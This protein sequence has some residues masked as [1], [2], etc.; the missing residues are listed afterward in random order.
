MRLGEVQ[1]AG[2]AKRP[3]QCGH[4]PKEMP[5]KTS[6]YLSGLHI[7]VDLL[8]FLA[9]RRR[10]RMTLAQ[11]GPFASVFE[12]RE[13]PVP[14]YLVLLGLWREAEASVAIDRVVE[15]M[16]R[17][18]VARFVARLLAHPN[19]RPHLVAAVAYLV[20]QDQVLRPE[21][22]WKAIDRGSWVIPQLVVTA[23]FVDPL[24]PV[25]AR[26]RVEQFCPVSVLGG[27]SSLERHSATGPDSNRA[28]SAK[29]MASLLEAA[30]LVPSMADWLSSTRANGDVARLLFADANTDSPRIVASWKKQSQCLFR[31]RG[32]LLAPRAT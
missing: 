21:W 11:F 22:I 20:D 12:P 6:K 18:S 7:V 5:L 30:S 3:T 15:A 27:L 29:M 4:Q 28:R 23:L 9:H 24:F 8:R 1:R 17:D 25:H 13:L 14:A 16:K 10:S 19:W 2:A 26:S 31:K 32:I